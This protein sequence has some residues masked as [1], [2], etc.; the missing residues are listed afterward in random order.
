MTK[1]AGRKGKYETH[2][3]PNLDWINEQVRNGVI[4]EEIAKELNISK[5]T[6]NNYK[7]AH[8]EFAEALSSNRGKDVLQKLINAGI[9]A[10]TGYYKEEE[11]TT[12]VLVGDDNEVGKKQKVI[13]KKWFP[14]NPTLNIYY[15]KIFG[16]DEGFTSDPLKFEL[17]KAKLDFEKAKQSLKDL[18]EY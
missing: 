15:T 3:Q 1:K 13:S 11:T 7:Q 14:A 16:K 12:I 17:D 8:P 2:V 18:H 9:E 5:A 4:E 6:L 10:A